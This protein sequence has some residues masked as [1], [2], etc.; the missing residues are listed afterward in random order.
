MD[1]KMH[2][3]LSIEKL[4]GDVQRTFRASG[5]TPSHSFEPPM[6]HG[7]ISLS[8]TDHDLAAPADNVNDDEVEVDDEKLLTVVIAFNAKL[9]KCMTARAKVA[10]KVD[11]AKVSFKNKFTIAKTSQT[12]AL[13]ASNNSIEAQ[14]KLQA[15]QAHKLYHEREIQK[16]QEEID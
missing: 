7:A 10:V 3:R 6:R 15:L 1:F 5:K 4:E 9:S 2:D 11:N 8:F 16:H 14:K 13:E 12:E